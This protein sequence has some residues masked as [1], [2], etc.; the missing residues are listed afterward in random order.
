MR[1]LCRCNEVTTQGTS[2][3]ART[4][5]LEADMVDGQI[6]PDP[7]RPD[8]PP[9][10]MPLPDH[11]ARDFAA[12]RPSRVA[13]V[14]ER[15]VS[16][17]AGVAALILV[18]A[19]IAVAQTGQDPP[20]TVASE[21][22]TTTALPTSTVDPTT[23]RPSP[24]RS[25]RTSSAAATAPSTTL[26]PA[27][28]A[29]APTP[30]TGVAAPSRPK[31]AVPR[32]VD[33]DLKKIKVTM[34]NWHG[35]IDTFPRYCDT[36][37]VWVDN[38]TNRYVTSLRVVFNTLVTDYSNGSSSDQAWGPNLDSGVRSVQLLPQDKWS[39]PLKVCASPKVLP[40]KPKDPPGVYL[41]EPR[42]SANGIVRYTVT[43]A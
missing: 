24:S 8:Q 39:V 1:R 41:A 28:T 7:R 38:P 5:R 12:G 16:L 36:P 35:S 6:P 26:P 4:D 37:R 25:T 2:L 34:D 19:G 9:L 40:K 14:R 22:A 11:R 33:P 29:P 27:V 42:L 43:L 3:A 15:Q 17:G 18:T 10:S 23:T 20:A 30:S 21:E 13:W 31:K 32:P